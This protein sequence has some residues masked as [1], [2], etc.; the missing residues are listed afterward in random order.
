MPHVL[1]VCFNGKHYPKDVILYAV[2]FVSR[3]DLEDIMIGDRAADI[4]KHGLVLSQSLRSIFPFE[5]SGL[6]QSGQ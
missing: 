3:H 6:T 1:M 2:F 4:V 5:G